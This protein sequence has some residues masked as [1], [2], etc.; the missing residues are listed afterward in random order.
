MMQRS[1]ENIDN[2]ENGLVEFQPPQ[3]FF[4]VHSVKKEELKALGDRMAFY[5]IPG[6]SIAV[7]NDFKLDWAKS[8]GILKTGTE[9]QV[10][11]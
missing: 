11:T 10:T 3:D 6:V 8:Y 1:I 7:I 5:N 9:G 4:Q 2:I